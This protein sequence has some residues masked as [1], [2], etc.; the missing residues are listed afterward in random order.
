[1]TLSIIPS[2]ALTSADIE[3]GLATIN[4]PLSDF[5]THCQLPTK[6]LLAPVDERR[7]VVQAFESVLE[8]LPVKD[9][10]RAAYISKFAICVTIGLFDGALSYLWDE[11]IKALRTKIIAFDLEYFYAVAQTISSRYKGLSDPKEIEAISEFDLLEISRR[12]G[13]IDDVNHRRLEQVNYFRNHASAAHP[14]NTM[15]SGIEILGFLENCL[16]YAICAEFDQSVVQVKRLLENIR[17]HEIDASDFPKIGSEVAK[18]PG[19]RIDDILKTI[20]GMYIDPNIAQ[21]VINNIKSLAPF[22]WALITEDTKL[23]VGAKFGYFRA[24]GDTAR[25][26]KVQEF[27]G[28]VDGNE[29]KDEDSLAEELIEKIQYLRSAHYGRNNFYNEYP[30]AQSI[31]QSLPSAGIPKAAKRDF[32][33]VISVCYIGNGLGYREGVDESALPFYEHF[34]DRFGDE[35]IIHFIKL[36]NDHEFTRDIGTIKGTSRTKQLVGIIRSKAKNVLMKNAL[37]IIHSS[38]KIERVA[39]TIDYK[40]AVAILS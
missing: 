20:F 29:Y 12:I 15:L 9:R 5:L 10:E 35:E 23:R 32:V 40:N 26:T 19:E 17:K 16:K 36:F 6:D 38:T 31:K 4:K 28:V 11:T 27:L 39:S 1:M 30:H 34:I 14:N 25:K 37:H 18:L 8:V 24:N 7:K 13:L 33:K 2:K 21:N 22:I 3:N